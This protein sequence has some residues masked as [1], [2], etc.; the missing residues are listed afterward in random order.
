MVDFNLQTFYEDVRNG[1]YVVNINTENNPSESGGNYND[2]VVLKSNKQVVPPASVSSSSQV[3]KATIPNSS[4]I[5]SEQSAQQIQSSNITRPSPTNNIP[6]IP[7]EDASIILKNCQVHITNA[8]FSIV[9]SD[10]TTSKNDNNNTTSDSK[11]NPKTT[12]P[13]NRTNVINSDKIDQNKVQ[14]AAD[15]EMVGE[16]KGKKESDSSEKLKEQ[17]RRKSNDV[18][19]ENDSE[20]KKHSNN[21]KNNNNDTTEDTTLLSK[22]F[23]INFNTIV[24]LTFLNQTTIECKT[25]AKLKEFTEL[26]DDLVA[27]KFIQDK[28][29]NVLHKTFDQLQKQIGE[30]FIKLAGID[31]LEREELSFEEMER[32]HRLMAGQ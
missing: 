12:E 21:N 18:Q 32:I 26:A 17:G 24:L 3:V 7:E 10:Q 23:T 13:Q 9:S 25:T 31:L 6:V 27:N 30:K 20:S 15:L 2:N 4:P 8:S 1:H 19:V 28:D 11:T 16:L 5:I 14:N 29:R 22:K